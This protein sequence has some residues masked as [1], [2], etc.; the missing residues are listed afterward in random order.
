MSPLASSR[1]VQWYAEGATSSLFSRALDVVNLSSF[2]SGYF[3]ERTKKID[4]F[5]SRNNERCMFGRKAEASYLMTETL[6]VQKLVCILSLTLPRR[7]VFVSNFSSEKNQLQIGNKF[8]K[9]SIFVSS[10]FAQKIPE[11]KKLGRHVQPK[12]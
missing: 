6:I 3:D 10:Y 4:D 11:R 12:S 2:R 7:M 1:N 8:G 5:L 9:V